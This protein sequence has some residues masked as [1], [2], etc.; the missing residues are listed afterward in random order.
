[1]EAVNII[2]KFLSNGLNFS[3]NQDWE[4]AYFY[5]TNRVGDGIF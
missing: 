2:E 1:M 3:S 5:N 4:T